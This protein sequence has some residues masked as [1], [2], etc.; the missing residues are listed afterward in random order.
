MKKWARQ[1]QQIIK[2]IRRT[3]KKTIFIILTNNSE[4]LP[5]Y[6]QATIIKIEPPTT[7]S[8]FLQEKYGV[9]KD[10]AEE[11][12]KISGA[13]IGKAISL[14]TENELLKKAHNSFKIG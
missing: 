3:S 4:D 13:N 7:L 14:V 11:T 12:A 10:L 1:H 5:H 9:E 6:V 2:T 8:D